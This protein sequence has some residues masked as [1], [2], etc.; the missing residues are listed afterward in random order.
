[1]N[2]RSPAALDPEA[3]RAIVAEVLRRIHGGRPPADIQTG[4][5]REAGLQ[6]ATVGAGRRPPAVP[7]IGSGRLQVRPTA[8][9]EMS[10]PADGASLSGRV[11]SLG[12]LEKLPAGLKRI[13]VEF[14]A[15]I[16]PSARDHARD[17]GIA[18]E[19]VSAA[20]GS[21][22]ATQLPF[23]VAHA[24]CGGNA[25]AQTAAIA[26]AVPAAA[27]LPASGLADVVAALALHASRDAA[28][29]IL[30]TS[31]PALATTLANR[32]A[33][34]RAV[35]ARDHAGL[36]A[37]AAE[38]NANLLVIDPASFPATALLRLAGSLA[39]RPAGETPAP[40]AARPAGCG[41]KGH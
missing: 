28:R 35:T 2:Q 34:L 26:R 41:C 18:I 8:A 12:M 25:S 32:S 29:G 19:R 39:A 14:A 1:M 4:D 21:P 20:G 27:Q 11:I 16:T 10:I 33:S 5:P 22:A 36:S 13:S 15:V 7:E 23:L 17:K 3:V 40:L 24:E 9:G 6:P 31:K 30:L 38:C 37:A